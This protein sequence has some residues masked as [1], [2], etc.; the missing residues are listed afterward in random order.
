MEFFIISFE[1]LKLIQGLKHSA[2]LIIGYMAIKSECLDQQDRQCTYNAALT[3]VRATTVVAK[4][5]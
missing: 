1:L 2:S 4:N 3:R 5:Q